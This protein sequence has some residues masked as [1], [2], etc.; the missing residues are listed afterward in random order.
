M[1]AR[2]EPFYDRHALATELSLP[3][4]PSANH[5]WRSNRGRVHKSPKY[6]KWLYAA[7][8][9]ALAAK[10]RGIIGAYKLSI[11]AVR[12]D[13]RRRDLDNIIKPINDLLKAVGVIED[14]S[15]C[16]MIC[17]RWVTSGMGVDVRIEPAGRE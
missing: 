13:N 16:E 7:G 1:L 2:T 6:E 14:D 15:D 10:P 17:A 12:P 11:A 9:M 3:Y 4:P 5:L 8:I